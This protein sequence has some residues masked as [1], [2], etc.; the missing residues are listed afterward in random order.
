MFENE[1]VRHVKFGQG[2]VIECDG[3]HIKVIFELQNLE[4]TFAYP[5]V[6]DKFLVFESNGLQEETDR[7][8]ADIRTEQKKFDNM[9]RLMYLENAK[10]HKEDLLAKA[11]QKKA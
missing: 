9:K 11:K 5:G 1:K 10:R 3:V 8:L 4:K 7:K 2:N 6:F